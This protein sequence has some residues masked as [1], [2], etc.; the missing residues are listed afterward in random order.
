MAHPLTGLTKKGVRFKWGE[1]CQAAFDLLKTT[2]QRPEV[3]A[4]PNQVENFV[5]DTDANLVALGANHSETTA[6]LIVNS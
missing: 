3:M 5:L 6:P 1:K 4:Y 2:L